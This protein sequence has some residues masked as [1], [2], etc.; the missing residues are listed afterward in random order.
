L[1]AGKA[2]KKE[3]KKTGYA[4]RMVKGKAKKKRVQ[5]YEWQQYK[6]YKKSLGKNGRL[7]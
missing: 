3:I 2:T 4:S 7:K 6:G 1:Y 5:E